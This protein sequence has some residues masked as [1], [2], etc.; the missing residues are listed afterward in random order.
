VNASGVS[1]TRNCSVAVVITL[2]FCELGGW[3]IW[4]RI[5]LPGGA[6][7]VNTLKLG[8]ASTRIRVL[9]DKKKKKKA[10]KML[11]VFLLDTSASMNQRCANGLSLLDCAKSAIEHFHKVQQKLFFLALAFIPDLDFC[12]VKKSSNSARFQDTQR[13][14]SFWNLLCFSCVLH[15]HSRPRLQGEEQAGQSAFQA[16]KREFFLECAYGLMCLDFML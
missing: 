6:A 9:C 14:E 5:N 8:D 13:E 7:A 16:T 1:G 11:V 12:K 4:W 2:E 15:S 3:R 10:A